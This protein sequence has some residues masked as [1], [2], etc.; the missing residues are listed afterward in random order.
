MRIQQH[1]PVQF[2]YLGGLDGEWNR[3]VSLYL[4]R[5]LSLHLQSDS[6]NPGVRV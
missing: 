3:K 5:N 2:I 6:T 4:V 1:H